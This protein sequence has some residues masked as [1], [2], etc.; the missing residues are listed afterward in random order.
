MLTQLYYRRSLSSLLHQLPLSFSSKLRPPVFYLLNL[1]CAY[2]IPS[3]FPIEMNLP[4]FPPVNMKSTWRLALSTAFH[5]HWPRS[6]FLG[7]YQTNNPRNSRHI[8][9]SCFLIP[10][11]R[12]L[13][14]G[15]FV[16]F[17]LP[18]ASYIPR[19]EW[20]SILN[21]YIHTVTKFNPYDSH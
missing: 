2:V 19:R 8:W 12:T 5:Q 6:N 21:N 14:P 3:Q 15:C 4:L 7:V 20:G 1:P 13:P 17:S 18:S 9:P 11:Y 16:D 10:I